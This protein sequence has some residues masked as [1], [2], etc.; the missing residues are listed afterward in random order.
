MSDKGTIA[1]FYFDVLRTLEEIGAP[2]MIIG[3][4]GAVAYGSTRVTYDVDIVV[5]LRE[6]HI[7]ALAE[8]YKP[9]RYYAD[10]VQMRD[11]I[12][13]GILFNL[14]D[15]ERGEKVDLIPI[16]MEPFYK[17][18]FTRRIKRLIEDPSGREMEAWFARPEDIIVGKLMAWK[19]YPSSRHKEDITAILLFIYAGMDTEL[20]ASFDEEYVNQ[21]ALALGDEVFTLWGRLK[22]SAKKAVSME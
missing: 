9:P 22:E 4:F 1:G 20:T 13:M 17:R 3:G 19:E 5:D 7:L 12:R 8:K 16:T 18:A 15:T 14:I 2:Y 6:E 10:P 21:E 11:S